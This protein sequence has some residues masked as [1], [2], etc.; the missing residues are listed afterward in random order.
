MKAAALLRAGGLGVLVFGATWLAA[1]LYWRASAT[2]VTSGHLLVWLL[3]LP[4]LLFTALLGL[5]ALLR[6]RRAGRATPPAGEEEGNAAS[7]AVPATPD[8]PLYLHAATAW[9][10][11][12][13]DPDV[14]AAALAN[15]SRPP[16]HPGL[17]DSM[18]LPVFAAEAGDV[19]PGWSAGWLGRQL[20]ERVAAAQPPHV[21]RALALLEPVAEDL[22]LA[23]AASV[24]NP[25]RPG[26]AAPAEDTGLHPH[27]MHHSRSARAPGGAAPTPPLCI[28]LLLPAAWPAPVREAAAARLAE[29]AAASGLDAGRFIIEACAANGPDDVWRALERAAAQDLDAPR[30]VLATESMLDP[31]RIEQFEARNQLLVSGHL[32]G[33]IP[34]EAA[35]GLL[36]AA[37]PL[38]APGERPPVRMHR[39][40]RAD[41]GRGREAVAGSARLLQDA[42]RTAGLEDGPRCVFTDADHRP[43][44]AVEAAGAIHAVLPEAELAVAARHLG[45]A[46]GDAGLAAPLVLLAAAAAHVHVAGAPVLV[47]GLA[48]D[49]RRTALALSPVPVPGPSPTDPAR[50]PETHAAAEAATA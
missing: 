48:G 1:V 28:Q 2:E 23:A 50:S 4:L 13:S 19:D 36:L 40:S 12:G 21:L 42:V 43:S 47:L 31:L 7:D 41:A 46:C 14:I 38:P 44:R 8:R 5:R 3:V 32:E 37:A 9:T 34:G 20:G 11:A 49:A 39:C 45:L 27:A 26:L 33:R 22:L 25:A 6:R 17:R 29:L 24:A 35:A 30:V 18:G 10:R 15:P 16:L